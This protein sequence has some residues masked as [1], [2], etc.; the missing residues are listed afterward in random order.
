MK[1]K[2]AAKISSLLL[3]VVLCAT[4]FALPAFAYAEDAAADEAQARQIGTVVTDGD[5]LNVRG[6]AGLDYEVFAQLPNGTMVEVVGTDGDWY[7]IHLADRDGYVHSD[8]LSVVGEADAGND[9]LSDEALEQLASLLEEGSGAAL[10]VEGNLAMLDDLGGA[11]GKQI[12]TVETRGGNVFYL[13]IDRDGAEGQTVH[14]LNQVD[15][16]DLMPLTENAAV[17]TPAVCSCEEKCRAGAV[18]TACVLCMTNMSECV[19]KEPEPVATAAPE[20]AATEAEGESGYAALLVAV[21][22]VVA[23]LVGVGLYFLLR[24][25]KKVRPVWDELDLEDEEEYLREEDDE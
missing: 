16:A 21:L 11:D 5:D 25:K 9:A 20:E 24:P 7:R 13:I 10:T 23:A 14:F 15:E 6:G 3:V 4:A 19:G 1:H 8:Y 2:Y 18:N 12:V 22:F 17:E